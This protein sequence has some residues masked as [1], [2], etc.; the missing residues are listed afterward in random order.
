MGHWIRDERK[1]EGVGEG[2]RA[3]GLGSVPT[4][5]S[6]NCAGQCRARAT[7][8][9]Q[10]ARRAHLMRLLTI[11]LLNQMVVVLMIAIFIPPPEPK[12]KPNPE[13]VRI[14]TQLARGAA[15]PHGFLRLRC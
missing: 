14:K 9:K 6:R 11:L 3:E 2:R 5:L 4:A 7:R 1:R 15:E 13:Q 10:R 12:P 8:A